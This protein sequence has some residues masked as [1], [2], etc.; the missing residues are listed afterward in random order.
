MSA[1]AKTRAVAAALA[2][3]L[4]SGSAGPPPP[5]EPLEAEVSF[6]GTP[7]EALAAIRSLGADE[8]ERAIA[9]AREL[10]TDASLAEPLRAEFRF[11]EG[12][13]TA[14]MSPTAS[15]D[16]FLSARAL[17]GPGELRAAATYDQGTAQLQHAE[18]LREEAFRQMTDPAAQGAASTAALED[19]LGPPRRAYL[20]AKRTLLE[21]LTSP[22]A[23]DTADARA[24][25]ELI[26]RRLRELDELEQDEPEEPQDPQ[27]GDQEQEEPQEGDEE[28]AQDEGEPGEDE[29]SSGEQ[30][31]EE[32]PGQE[33]QQQEQPG[34]PDV[35]APEQEPAIPDTGEI[36]EEVPPAESADA[37][38]AE[39]VLSREEVLRLL[40]TLAELEA[41][42]E[43]IDAE[44]RAVRR[45][46]V[47]EDW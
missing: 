30:E 15:I 31:Q 25:L 32:R 23:G 17:A 42:R 18:A 37:E 40:D 34:E 27:A 6:Q 38:S 46:P 22:N 41:E 14:G 10:A 3:M 1:A 5:Q 20:A 13:V 8:P 47:K 28:Q 16:A 21:L 7:R 19:P 35:N 24:N 44:L 9:L 33:E 29:G 11:A 45:V 12:V 36:P 2:A 4:V 26:Q 39:R 43:K